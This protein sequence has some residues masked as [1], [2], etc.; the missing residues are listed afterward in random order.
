MPSVAVIIPCYNA[1]RFLLETVASVQK[2]TI[3]DWELVLVDDGSTDHTRELCETLVSVDSRVRL[4]CQPNGKQ[5]KA[6][7]TGAAQVSPDVRYLYFLDSD[8][9]LHP[10]ALRVL[11]FELDQHPDAG[12]VSSEKADID[13]AGN[14]HP[15][16]TVR[17]WAPGF[18]GFPR[19]LP[20][21]ATTTPFT[22]YY[23]GTGAGLWVLYRRSTFEILGG[24]DPAFQGFED[25][26]LMARVA[27]CSEARHVPEVLCYYRQH[28]SQTIRQAGRMGRMYEQFRIKWDSY[29]PANDREKSLLSDARRFHLL[30]HEPGR[31]IRL[32]AKTM[33]ELLRHPTRQTW[34]WFRTNLKSGLTAWIKGLYRVLKG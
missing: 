26:D 22:T 11:S 6:R 28:E 19:L 16:S 29:V 13:S 21:N 30:W 20:A 8:D 25:N 1:I 3:S 15:S 31:H 32:C 18:L 23:C 17:R 7:N 34:W 12:M 33:P 5:A 9:L 2:Q 10:D 27:L 14:I 24:W 4:I